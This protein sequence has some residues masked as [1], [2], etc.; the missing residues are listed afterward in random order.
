MANERSKKD[1]AFVLGTDLKRNASDFR[2][3][4]GWFYRKLHDYQFPE[5]EVTQF[6]DAYEKKMQSV[7]N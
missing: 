3:I 2:E 5:E 1:D 7:R 6:I 4:C